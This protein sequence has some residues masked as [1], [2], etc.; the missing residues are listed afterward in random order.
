METE[1]ESNEFMTENIALTTR[2]ILNEKKYDDLEKSSILLMA[3]TT[4]GIKP[5]SSFGVNKNNKE[6]QIKN[7]IKFGLERQI[8]EPNDQGV[9]EMVVSNSS[10]IMSQYNK[11]DENIKD[12]DERQ[13]QL[14]KIF[15]FP[16]SAT[17]EFIN[18]GHARRAV[19]FWHDVVDGRE[20]PDE[21]IM[22]M[23]IGQLV[24]P[25]S[26]DQ[27]TIEYGGKIKTLLDK[28]DPSM[29]KK[30]VEKGKNNLLESAKTAIKDW[31][32]DK[33]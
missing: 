17:K 4:A 29:T 30:Y 12:E 33:K 3:V 2:N 14:G 21:I 1:L 15:G 16:E 25:S 11:T 10:D 8:A 13:R 24:P 5:V 27:S 18:S 26:D 22:A 28:I 20:I 32:I 7:A 9:H 23:E 31:E 6:I 19:K